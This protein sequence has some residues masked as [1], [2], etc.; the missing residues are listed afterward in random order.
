MH[1]LAGLVAVGLILIILVDGFEAMVL[2]RRVMRPYRPARLFYR[3]TWTL[4][5][6]A[7]GLFRTSSRR[8][9][10]LSGY[11]PLSL[12]T[13][14]ALWLAGLVVGFGLL[15]WA[16]GSASGGGAAKLPLTTYLYMSG[17]TLFTIGYGDVMPATSSGRLLAVIEGGTGLGTL[18]VIVGYLPVLY[19][20]FSQRERVIGMFD[21]RAGSPPTAGE[22]V[23]RMTEAKHLKAANGFLREWE[24]WSTELLES[25]LS[26]PVLSYY[27]SQHDNQSWLAALTA[28]L[29][30]CA[31][32]LVGI[33]GIDKYQA[34]LT[35]AMARHAA[36][37]LALIFWTPPE[38]P[39]EDRVDCGKLREL[40]AQLAADDCVDCDLDVAVAR[41]TQLRGL[42]EPFLYGL[43]RYFKLALPPMFPTKP[44]VDNWQTSAWMK[45]TPG[46]GDLSSPEDEHFY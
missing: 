18:A 22:L 13:L 23:R 25:H 38:G 29:D 44:A 37:D 39:V 45:R 30:T 46:I 15:H 3:S 14:F 26:F 16:I 33:Q 24:R 34:Q 6:R 1:A 20:A 8:E 28:I 21:A 19:Q 42:Y 10:F 27:R 12:L 5:R 9:A 36:V 11:G 2:P 7:S 31:L 17:T 35:F 41:L 4:W 43:S 40:L 32:A